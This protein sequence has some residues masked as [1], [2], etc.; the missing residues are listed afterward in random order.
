[1]NN[2]EIN[3]IND[4]AKQVAQLQQEIN[5][6][7]HVLHLAPASSL[8]KVS[9]EKDVEIM[10]NL[11]FKIMGINYT[12][13]NIK[14]KKDLMS[15]REDLLKEFQLQYPNIIILK[16]DSI[17]IDILNIFNVMSQLLIHKKLGFIVN[18]YSQFITEAR[19]L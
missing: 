4:I 14:L 10:F 15:F 12:E 7:K 18:E 8:D 9:N 13:F 6:I 17:I 11:L 5:N 1:M 16:E 2:I 19:F 3:D